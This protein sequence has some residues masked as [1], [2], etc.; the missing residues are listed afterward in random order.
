PYYRRRHARHA[1]Q[2]RHRAAGVPSGRAHAMT[3]HPREGRGSPALSRRHLLALGGLAAVAGTGILAGC[4]RPP[5][6]SSTS[7]SPVI[8]SRPDNPVTLPTYADIPAI[9]DGL[10]PETGGVLKLYNYDDYISPDVIK[11]F[12][13]QYNV[14]VQVTTFVTQDEAVEKLRT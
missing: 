8:L 9:A 1:G 3:L 4:G 2:R 11:A 5:R 7:T 6:P 10:A 13:D 12:G 14:D